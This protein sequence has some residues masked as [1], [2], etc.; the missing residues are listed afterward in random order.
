VAARTGLTQ[1]YLSLIEVGQQNVTI[2]TMALL[3]E[4][5]DH[6]LVGLLQKTSGPPPKS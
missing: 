4:V 2:R 1:Q 6:D 5:V 3:A